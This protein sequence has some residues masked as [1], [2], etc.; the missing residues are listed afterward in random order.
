MPKLVFTIAPRTGPP[1]C[2]DKIAP[3]ARRVMHRR[4]GRPLR[5][6]AMEISQSSS[7]KLASVRSRRTPALLTSPSSR[8]N[9]STA[10]WIKRARGI[11]IRDIGAIGNRLATQRLDLGDD[12]LGR[13]KRRRRRHFQPPPDR[14]PPPTSRRALMP[15]HVRAPGRGR[16]QLQWRRG[17]SFHLAR[18]NLLRNINQS[19]TMQRPLLI[20]ITSRAAIAA[21]EGD[22]FTVHPDIGV[23]GLTGKYR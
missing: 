21:A 16:H 22:G 11:P 8:P 5:F 3:V 1:V 7:V 4:G 9:T 17:Q 19:L 10:F 20:E 23:N 18:R 6:T 2:L 12:G 14:S 15:A 13:C